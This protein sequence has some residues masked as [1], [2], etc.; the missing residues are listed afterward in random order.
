[1][2]LSLEGSSKGSSRDFFRGSFEAV[3]RV[4]VSYE[5]SLQGV[6]LGALLRVPSRI[7][8]LGVSDILPL[9]G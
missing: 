8:A 7:E 6:D 2:L 4:R 5:G 3:F 9:Y 1:M